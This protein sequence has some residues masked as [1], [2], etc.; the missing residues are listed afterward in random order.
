MV[1][2]SSRRRRGQGR[3]SQLRGH[4]LQRLAVR[5]FTV[6]S[7]WTA[8]THSIG[9]IFTSA[10]SDPSWRFDVSGVFPNGTFFFVSTPVSAPPTIS[11][12][13]GE[14]VQGNWGDGLGTFSIAPD[15]STMNL[16][17]ASPGTAVEG[18][19]RFT[20]EGTPANTACSASTA[21]PPY[22]ESAA[23]GQSLSA[24][25]NIL[26]NQL[27]WAV[28]AP[29]NT[30]EMDLK[31]NGTPFQLTGTTGYHDHNWGPA[32]FDTFVY[33]WVVGVG[34]CGPYDLAY[35]GA[36]PFGSGRDRDVVGGFLAKDGAI[37]QDQCE[38]FGSQSSNNITI[39]FGGQ[40]L[41]EATN[42]T[43]PTN[44]TLTYDVPG[45]GTYQFNLYTSVIGSD[46][47][48]LY[49]RWRLGGTGG[50]LGGEQFDCGLVV[51]WLNPGQAT[52]SES[53]PN[54]FDQQ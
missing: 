11:T 26:Y 40:A 37:L 20:N 21:D 7:S 46:V 3:R 35:A 49:K 27:G 24:S 52:Y 36:R 19:V 48:D 22:F 54:I 43:V 10:P 5:A 30:V 13:G 23:A 18:T 44:L 45:S 28:T 38:L 14:A 12:P 32:R 16:T 42:T 2:V 33:T 53:G 8:L 9:F 31:I 6:K 51:D 4:F 47:G 39:Q 50:L 41:D 17:F 15:R 34:S 25:E 1:V 29:R